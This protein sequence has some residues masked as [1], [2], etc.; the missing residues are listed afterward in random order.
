[1]PK[2]WIIEKWYRD[3]APGLKP[4]AIPPEAVVDFVLEPF[5]PYG[6][7]YRMRLEHNIF[8]RYQ[9]GP[10]VTVV[11]TDGNRIVAKRESRL[12]SGAAII[13]CASGLAGYE[14]DVAADIVKLFNDIDS[15]DAVEVSRFRLSVLHNFIK[16]VLKREYGWELGER[17]IV[18]LDKP[19][20]SSNIK[21]C[22]VMGAVK[23][24]KEEMDANSQWPLLLK[25]QEAL[26][27]L[28]KR[29]FSDDGSYRIV[30]RL[31]TYYF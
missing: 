29:Q 11:I 24:T 4:Q 30:Q 16:S 6:I 22:S 14:K 8:L 28:R 5:I 2:R 19:V 18:F 17:K 26:D 9:S 27:Y 20:G 31:F 21:I 12:V 7:Q 23:I 3:Y 25:K 10:G 1:M 13:K 15:E